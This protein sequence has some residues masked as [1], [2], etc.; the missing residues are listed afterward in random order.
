[1]D[2]AAWLRGLGLEE[3]GPAFRDNGNPPRKAAL[4]SLG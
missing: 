1:M 4:V 3:Y 2:I